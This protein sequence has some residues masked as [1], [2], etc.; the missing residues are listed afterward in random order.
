MILVNGSV[1]LANYRT[2]FIDDKF[3]QQPWRRT[4][5][6]LILYVLAKS[7]KPKIHA[8]MRSM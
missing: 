7:L 2:Y 8:A 4:N 1:T 3:S 6:P 5:L